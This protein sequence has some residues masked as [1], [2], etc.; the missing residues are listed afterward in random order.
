MHVLPFGCRWLQIAPNSVA[1]TV[2]A[3]SL[4]Q[5]VA[6][7]A[8]LCPSALVQ[9]SV[10]KLLLYLQLVKACVGTLTLADA[11]A[12]VLCIT[13][14]HDGLLVI[15]LQ[16]IKK[17]YTAKLTESAAAKG[18]VG[19][20]GA[21]LLGYKTGGSHKRSLSADS[22]AS[23]LSG[24]NAADKLLLSCAYQMLSDCR[25]TAVCPIFCRPSKGLLGR[26]G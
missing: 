16:R 1:A 10:A 18:A 23:L 7:F 22:L 11:A 20:A 17:L 6:A 24:V 21:E 9:Q 26:S 5:G 14:L 4:L 3:A 15:G 2:A 12:G 25:G 19:A 13:L 8:V